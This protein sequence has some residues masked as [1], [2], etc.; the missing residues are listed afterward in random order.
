M[1]RQ[2]REPKVPDRDGTIS[3]NDLGRFDASHPYRFWVNE[4]GNDAQYDE[5]DMEDFFP[6]M[7]ISPPD[8]SNVTFALSADIQ[9]N[10]IQTAMT[11]MTAMTASNTQQYLHDIDLAQTLAGQIQTLNVGDQ[12]PVIFNANDVVLLAAMEGSTNAHIMVHVVENGSEIAVST[13]T[14]S[15]TSVTDM[16][17]IKNLCSGGISSTNEP[18]NWPDE[19]TNGKDLLFVHGFNVSEDAASEWHEN[20]FKRLWFA[21]SNAKYH[22]II[23]DGIG[24]GSL[25]THYQNSVVN[26]FATAP[27]LADYIASLKG[28]ETVV[29]GHSLGNMVVSSAICDDDAPV[30]QYYAIDAAVALEAYGDVSTNAALVPDVVFTWDREGF[31]RYKRSKWNDYPFETWASEWYRLFPED[32]PRAK[33]TFRHKF[34]AIQEKTDVFNFYSSTEDVL[35]VRDDVNSTWDM[36][37]DVDIDL[38]M[39][40]LPVSV[41]VESQC[42]WQ[43]QEM[44]KGMNNWALQYGGGG[45]SKY[46]GWSFTEEEGAHIRNKRI[47]LNPLTWLNKKY[48]EKPYEVETA[49]NPDPENADVRAVYLETLKT[50]PLF[51]RAPEILFDSS[52][53][54]FAGGVVG[55]YE[56]E[57]DYDNGELLG[58][59]DIDVSEVKIYDWLI[60]KG[61]P[62][63]TGPMGSSSVRDIGGGWKDVNF[64][65]HSEFMTDFT[66]WP[67]E[68]SDGTKIWKHSDWK[69]VPYVHVYKLFEIITGKEN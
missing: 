47:L 6:A 45:S 31:L 54:T 5:A 9:I 43:M 59:P 8:T 44:S 7:L 30:T 1:W 64:N 50:D 61:F 10:Y 69:N 57:L 56:S 68:Q 13:N 52:A 40:L 18:P 11:A 15:F 3:T 55:D 41:S 38:S 2:T 34:A 36:I 14:F 25:L 65:M 16:Y 39:H 37:T 33:L 12:T 49:L 63:R 21:G 22:G 24:Q 67:S 48:S 29:L 42:A 46:A 27:W 20:I 35:R 4:D 28:T 51:N 53:V 17:R 26:A 32:D 58:A 19:L 23:W 62:S 60:A 66:R